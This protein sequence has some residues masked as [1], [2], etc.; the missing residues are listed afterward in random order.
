[1]IGSDA[2][3]PDRDAVTFFADLR[4]RIDRGVEVAVALRDAR[5]DWRANGGAAWVDHLMVFE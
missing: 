5:R 3:L 4:A 2:P 1:M